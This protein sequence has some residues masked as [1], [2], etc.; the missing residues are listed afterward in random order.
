MARHLNLFLY[1]A[2]EVPLLLGPLSS[3]NSLRFQRQYFTGGGEFCRLC[4]GNLFPHLLAIDMLINLRISFSN[5]NLAQR[6]F[7]SNFRK[8]I[9]SSPKK[10]P[11][12]LWLSG[13]LIRPISVK[14][15][16]PSWPITLY[17]FSYRSTFYVKHLGTQNKVLL[18]WGQGFEQV[19][20]WMQFY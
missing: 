20:R 7:L 13:I 14:S 8:T 17:Y 12:W 5:R 6:I 9:L 18:G 2:K 16:Y 1:K 11:R 15:W 3:S 10:W 19:M 4:M